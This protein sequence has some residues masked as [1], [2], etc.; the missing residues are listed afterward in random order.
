MSVFQCFDSVIGISRKQDACVAG[1]F[2]DT[3]LSGLY[4]DELQG[5]GMRILNTTGGNNTL[6]EKMEN[7]RENGIN[8]FKVDVMARILETRE[9]ARSKFIG[10]IGGKSFSTLLSADTYHGIRMYSDVI[11]GSFTLRGVTLMLNVSEAVNLVIYSGETDQ[12]GAAALYTIPLV[13][14]AGRQRYNAITPIELPLDGNYYF[15]Y[16][17]TGQPYNNYL[18]CNC[19]GHKWC[20]NIKF[21]CY[22]PSRDKWTEWSMAAG[23]HGSD[24][25]ERDDWSTSRE[26]RGLILHGEYGCDTLGI[27]CSDH[28]DW[29]GDMVDQSIA[30][31]I[32]YKAGSFLSTYVMDSE[33]ISRYTLLGVDGLAANI[34]FYEERYKA[35]IDF[36]AANI[37]TARNECLKC[38]NPAGYKRQAQFL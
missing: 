31:A 7:A 8:A 14:S 13:S 28:S 33:E 22:R 15:L 29:S 30:W 38:K 32:L 36:I 35:M 24:L 1:S 6:L 3:S 10:D 5:L 20:F 17:T 21:P 18:T 4:L 11:G 27:L 19:G 9:P 37:E 12:D 26:A 16:Q 34:T 2:A 25:T 23:V